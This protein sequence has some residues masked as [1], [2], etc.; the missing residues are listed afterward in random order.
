M[1]LNVADPRFAAMLNWLSNNLAFE[2]QHIEPASADASFRRYFRVRHQ[3]GR[4]IVMDAPPDRENTEPFVRI[5]ALFKAAHVRVPEV[6][7]IDRQL[8]FLLL[9]D[10]GSERLLDVLTADNVDVFYQTALQNLLALQTGVNPAQNGLPAYDRPL[11]ERELAIF[12]DWFLEKLLGLVMP[13]AL[14]IDLH[15]LLIESALAQPRV[16]VHRDYHARNLM[17]LDGQT[18]GMI[19]FQDAVIGPISYDVASLLRDCYIAWPPEQVED[20]LYRYYRRAER[21]GLL[22]AGFVEFKRWFDLM[23]LQRHLKAI[24][25]FARLYLRDDK[26]GYL[27]DIPRTL[28]YIG[29]VCGDYPEFSAFRRFLELQV[30]PIYR[31]A[32]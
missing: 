15:G 1:S 9:E 13:A 23:G 16:C 4:H 6:Y 8:G 11:L 27:A 28:G 3:Q 24:G 17:V 21:A 32:L 14:K 30:L 2:I 5:A 31:A 22:T 25:I 19:D 29:A 7:R 18:L 12:H 20:S 10:F 26:P